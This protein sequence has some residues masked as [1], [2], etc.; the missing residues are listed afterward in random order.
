MQRL[1]TWFA[2]LKLQYK[3]MISMA[4]VTTLALLAIIVTTYQNYFSTNFAAE[5][6]K[7]EQAVSRAATSLN[8]T[9]SSLNLK[10]SRL[11]LESTMKQVVLMLE[12]DDMESYAANYQDVSAIMESYVDSTD[13]LISA[14]LFSP[15][16]LYGT[17]SAGTQ[18][19][20]Y[21]IIDDSIWLL[22]MITYRPY[23]YNNQTQTSRVVPILYP[24]TSV[25]AASGTL[26]NYGSSEHGLPVCFAA[27]LDE[28]FLTE[29]LS[30]FSTSMTDGF[31]LLNSDGVP[32]NRNFGAISETTLSEINQYAMQYEELRNASLIIAGDTYYITSQ[33]VGGGGLRVVHIF[34]NSGIIKSIRPMFLFLILI[35]ILGIIASCILSFV[36]AHFLTRPFRKLTAVINRINRNA[37]HQK[38][39][40]LY[41]DE[42]GL[43]GKQINQM[44]DT[45]QQQIMV[46][47][48]EEQQKA[49]A[50]IQMYTE[51]INPHFLYNTLEC[52]HFQM[53][54]DHKEVAGLMLGSLA[55][56]LRLTLSHGQTIIPLS[57]EIEHATEY[58]SII[59]RHSPTA[60]IIF[61]CTCEE[62]LLTH[63]IIK[64]LLQPII[65]N[66][67]KHGFPEDLSSYMN[68]P[69]ISIDIRQQG[70]YITLAVT[71]N[72]KGFDA[73][74][75]K[76]C[77]TDIS[78]EQGTH[79]GLRNVYKRLVTYYGDEAGIEFMSVPYYMNSVTIRLPLK[80]E[81]SLTK[82]Q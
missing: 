79:F 73:V 17:M 63:R 30:R 82:L 58:M 3:L 5:M 13:M 68:P 25:Y 34:S 71:D 75:A 38:A 40:F 54:N 7:S 18:Q 52:I 2:D 39:E 55:K 26:L 43:L 16:F 80:T 46:I 53:L 27:F 42:S 62:A 45:I 9:F 11:L 59:N 28:R 66:A 74:Y 77:M 33:T 50:E 31:Y 37:Y 19:N 76:S 44:Y 24:V 41:Q 57:K 32:L 14:Y 48:E 12:L 69:S 61:G 65:E 8:T 60:R 15:S 1:K 56:Y 67:L 20:P 6:D 35:W 51:Q 10:T 4:G 72:G 78:F 22:D 49:K 23:S 21:Q 47:K 29:T 70:N 81:Q 64:L 36:I